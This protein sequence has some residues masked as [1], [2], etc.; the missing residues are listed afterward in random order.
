MDIVTPKPKRCHI[1][2]AA[3]CLASLL[4]LASCTD[5]G[6]MPAGTVA[7]PTLTAG[8][9]ATV[10]YCNGETAQITEPATLDGRAPTAVYVHGGA[11]VSGNYDTGGFIISAVGP[12]L[13]S[14]GFVVMRIDYRLGLANPWPDQIEDVKCAI[15]YL[16]AHAKALNVNPDEIGA[17]GHSAGGQLVNLLATAGPKAGWDVGDFSNESSRIEAVV[18]LAG[19]SDLATLSD[20]R[21]GNLV[22]SS[23]L[24]LLGPVQH[25][26]LTRELQ[27]ASPVT[28]I[29]AGDPPFLIFHSPN[30]PFVNVQ[31]S[32]ELAWDLAQAGVPVQLVL[33]HGGSHTFDEPGESPDAAQ[34][35]AMIVDFFVAHLHP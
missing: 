27:E 5:A 28:Y 32:E 21:A 9:T 30:D 3:L 2:P 34:I 11:W 14:H 12:A 35:T 20:R 8:Q 7:P 22:N 1:R 29:R 17:W 18:D 31:Q 19:P 13:A 15:R 16:R 10:T 24:S 6:S 26:E 25:Y 4:G 23:F 33:V